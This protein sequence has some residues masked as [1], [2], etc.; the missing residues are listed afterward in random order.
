MRLG[1]EVVHLVEGRVFD[2]ESYELTS[3]DLELT[4]SAPGYYLL[5]HTDDPQVRRDVPAARFVGPFANEA[6]AILA[7]SELKSLSGTIEGEAA[8]AA[9]SPNQEAGS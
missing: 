9:A 5:L 1:Y 3:V 8:G 4:R 7:I 6:C 2:A